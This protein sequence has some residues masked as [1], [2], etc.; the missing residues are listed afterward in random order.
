LGELVI[1]SV[2][3]VGRWLGIKLGTAELETGLVVGTADSLPEGVLRVGSRLTLT[4]GDADG[5]LKFGEPLGWMLDITGDWAKGF[6]LGLGEVSR[7]GSVLSFGDG[8]AGLPVRMDEG[9]VEGKLIGNLLTSCDGRK[10]GDWIGSV[11]GANDV[12]PDG[13]SVILSRNGLLETE[14]LGAE[15]LSVIGVNEG[16]FER[17]MV[18]RIES[19]I[20]G[21]T[22][23]DI[24]DGWK[25][26]AL[27]D[28]TVDGDLESVKVGSERG[29]DDKLVGWEEGLIDGTADG[30]L[31]CPSLAFND[32]PSDSNN[33][34]TVVGII[35]GVP[36]G[37]DD[38]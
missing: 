38:G 34:E 4:L 2:D 17:M 18:G 32:G 36:L 13:D 1:V 26:G 11:L 23:R 29:M 21:W 24:S 25:V 9:V 12:N 6:I 37:N 28:G 33:D 10:L 19:F 7:V 27:N 35:D 3:K 15:V 31:P 8:S 16:P 22:L 30:K 14:T 20:T 5:L